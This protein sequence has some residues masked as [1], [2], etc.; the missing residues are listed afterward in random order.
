MGRRIIVATVVWLAACS[1]DV[2]FQQ[3]SPFVG[4]WSCIQNESQQFP[5]ATGTGLPTRLRYVITSPEQGQ[6]VVASEGDAGSCAFQFSA[7]GGDAMLLAGQSCQNLGGMTL[8]Y[9][10]GSASVAGEKL[11]MTFHYDISGAGTA[12]A[13]GASGTGVMTD[14]CTR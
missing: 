6:L 13:P 11:T 5:D 10:S 14:D 4:E 3:T 12:G 9:T 8:A 1:N 2:N 7:Q